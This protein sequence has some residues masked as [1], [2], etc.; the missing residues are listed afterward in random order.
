MN[1][2]QENPEY[3]KSHLQNLLNFSSQWFTC[4]NGM[5]L[6][7][8]LDLGFLSRSQI[9]N[10]LCIISSLSLMFSFSSLPVWTEVNASWLSICPL[11]DAWREDTDRNSYNVQEEHMP[12]TDHEA[13]NVTKI[14][15]PFQTDIFIHILTRL[16]RILCW[17]STLNDGQGAT[18]RVPVSSSG[19][20]AQTNLF[21]C[22]LIFCVHLSV[23]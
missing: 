23:K 12:G 15:P 14:K 22:L 19:A 5:I 10:M 17:S 2:Q 3:S 18:H 6:L 7:C 4:P 1:K 16:I 13:E 20:Q 21:L 11:V 8:Q 9:I